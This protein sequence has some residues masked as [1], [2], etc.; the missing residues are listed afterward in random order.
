MPRFPGTIA[1]FWVAHFDVGEVVH[2]DAAF[3][4]VVNP[5]LPDARRVMV[6]DLVDGPVSA[7][8]TPK[9]AR[10]LRLGE[11]P[12]DTEAAFRDRLR[13]AGIVLHGADRI[14]YFSGAEA[15]LVRAEPPPDEVRLLTSADEPAFAAFAAAA[16]AQDRDDAYVELG[17]WAVFG[18]FAE[19]R[20][21]CAASAY[22]WQDG[23]LADIGVLTLAAFRGQGHARRVVRAI[24]RH[25][26]RAGYQPQYRC[27]LDNAAS[28]AVAR[29][30]GL[31]LF[32]T[33]EVISS[34]EGAE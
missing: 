17:H 9:L 1:E 32:A 18:A 15:D 4:L 27:Q 23:P 8:V 33:W 3:V 16:T 26:L 29:S 25:A 19:G 30:A 34:A 24:S 6:L 5:A 21:V 10:S 12:V 14:F 7:V 28:A 22:P 31:T 13:D 11:Q 2:R 20:L